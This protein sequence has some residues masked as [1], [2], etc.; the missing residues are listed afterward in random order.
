MSGILHF[1]LVGLALSSSVALAEPAATGGA[2]QVAPAASASMN[3]AST[4]SAAGGFDGPRPA[5]NLGLPARETVAGLAPGEDL[6]D[7]SVP[8]ER[9][10]SSCGSDADSRDACRGYHQVYGVA[11]GRTGPVNVKKQAAGLGAAMAAAAAIKGV[12]T[13]VEQRLSD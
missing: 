8:L 10:H 9:A 7:G 1:S 6:V 13:L 4:S 5:L 11:A 3:N 2:V 12:R